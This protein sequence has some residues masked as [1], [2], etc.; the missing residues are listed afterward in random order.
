[1]IGQVERMSDPGKISSRRPRMSAAILIVGL[2]LFSAIAA[3]QTS[4]TQWPVPKV[5]KNLVPHPNPTPHPRNS[6][7]FV[8]ASAY[9]LSE[10][11]LNGTGP[12]TEEPISYATINVYTASVPEIFVTSNTTNYSG[13][14]Y[15]GIP[16]GNYIVSMNSSIANLT[17]SVVTQSGNT[18]ELD[19]L[20]NETSYSA[21]S[22]VIENTASPNFILPWE[23][24]LLRLS[25]NPQTINDTNVADYL[26]FL[27]N[28][29]FSI[30]N[31]RNN[32]IIILTFS[33][34]IGVHVVNTFGTSKGSV[35]LQVEPNS[36]VNLA[37]F[38]N[39]DFLT[40]VSSYSTREYSMSNST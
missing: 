39:V 15:L 17:A 10:F 6:T 20:A 32:T 24:V 23:N 16:A 2:I 22:F 27:T 3:I 11:F 34:Q 31:D 8:S 5:V 7:L 19:I 13:Q 40:V 14:L 35:W 12:P 30:T 4:E 21:T 25:S 26:M 28:N 18:T 1:M 36:L 38:S 9:V 29:G 33:E 37:N